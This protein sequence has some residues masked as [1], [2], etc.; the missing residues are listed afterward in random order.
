MTI[1]VRGA[2]AADVVANPAV[3]VAT[4]VLAADLPKN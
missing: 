3:R 2:D 1:A 4:A